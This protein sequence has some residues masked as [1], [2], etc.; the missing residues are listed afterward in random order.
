MQFSVTCIYSY[1]G[2]PVCDVLQIMELQEAAQIHQA[3]QH[4]RSNSLHDM[5]ATIKTWRN[6]LP[7]IADDLSHWSDIFTWRQHHY[8][9]IASHFNSQHDQ[10]VNSTLGVH[11]SAQVSQQALSLLV[12]RWQ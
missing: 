7:V 5:K 8:T 9:F 11:A 2:H 1:V 10:T 3:L 12:S 6:R 4:G